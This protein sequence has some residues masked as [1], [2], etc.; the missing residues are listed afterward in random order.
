MTADQITQTLATLTQAMTRPS[1]TV[2]TSSC[3]C[4]TCRKAGKR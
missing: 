4:P 3:T 2:T 1:A